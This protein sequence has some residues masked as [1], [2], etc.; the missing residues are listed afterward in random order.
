MKRDTVPFIKGIVINSEWQNI[1]SISS[2]NRHCAGL[3]VDGTIVASG[4]NDDGQCRFGYYIH[5]I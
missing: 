2:N 1:V 3:R 4:L 5:P